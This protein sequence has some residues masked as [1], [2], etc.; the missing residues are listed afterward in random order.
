MHPHGV[1]FLHRQRTDKKT[2]LLRSVE[3]LNRETLRILRLFGHKNVRRVYATVGPEQEYFLIDRAVYERRPD[4]K[5][6]GRTLFGARPAKGQEMD[7]QYFGAL[8]T[9][10]SA[11]M[12]ELDEEL[13]KLGVF[14][15]RSTTRPR[16]RSTNW[17]RCLPT[18]TS[19]PTTTS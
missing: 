4:L 3:A 5:Y 12:R 9:R 7:D 17:P 1:L 6:T 13:W 11:F 10:I 19:P 16:P 14:A 15:A 8:K 2:P 18:S